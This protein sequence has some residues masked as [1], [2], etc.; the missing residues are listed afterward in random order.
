MGK[1][2]AKYRVNKVPWRTQ[3]ERGTMHWGRWYEGPN[4]SDYRPGNTEDRL[5]NV[6]A[7]F[8]DAEWQDRKNYRNY[9]VMKL[10]YSMLGVFLL[11]RLTG[12]CRL[13]GAMTVARRRQSEQPSAHLCRRGLRAVGELSK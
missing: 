3:I 8:T 5:T 9:D 1:P 2:S 6:R 11:Y 12:E 10:G 4:G 13:F 7:P